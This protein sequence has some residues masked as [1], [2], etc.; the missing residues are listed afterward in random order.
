MPTAREPNH[1]VDPYRPFSPS[2]PGTCWRSPAEL[3]AGTTAGTA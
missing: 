2:S 1:S 3:S